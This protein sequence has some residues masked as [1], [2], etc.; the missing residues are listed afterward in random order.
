MNTQNT[1]SKKEH[2]CGEIRIGKLFTGGSAFIVYPIRVVYSVVDEKCDANVRVLV[3]VPKRRFKHAVDRN[4]IK[5]LL[6]EA[7]RLNKQDFVQAAQEKELYLQVAFNYVADTEIDF[8]TISEKIK[9]G[10]HKIRT[11]SEF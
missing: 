6:R 5:R 10:L 4:R 9:L 7:Y 2:L 3:N 1:F 11:K 8:A